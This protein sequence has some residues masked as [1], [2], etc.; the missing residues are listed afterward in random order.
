MAVPTNWTELKAAVATLANR[1]DTDDPAFLQIPDFIAYAEDYFQKTLFM[2]EREDV[3]TLVVTDGVAPLPADFGGAKTVYVDGSV[4]R[5][6]VQVTADQ[7]RKLYP[8]SEANTPTNYAI[9][10]ETMLIGPVPSTGTVIKLRYIE[11]IPA[12]GAGQ[13]TNWLLTDHP[14][15]YVQG[16]LAELYDYT[17]DDTQ[18]AKCR[19]KCAAMIELANQ[20]GR[21]RKGNSGPL[22]TN[23]P[24]RQTSRWARC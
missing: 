20:S 14:S 18:A 4:D 16:A 13:A 1:D 12:L 19:A 24:V 23:S 5:P 17:R 7:I 10:G 8:T 6:L 21:R 9:E 15:I 22:V 3:A 11:G 2:P